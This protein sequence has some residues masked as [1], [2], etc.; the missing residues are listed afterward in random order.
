LD[1]GV[2]PVRSQMLSLGGGIV[3]WGHLA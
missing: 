2:R 1:A 3:T